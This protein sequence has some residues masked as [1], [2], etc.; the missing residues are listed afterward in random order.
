[1][2]QVTALEMGLANTT[3]TVQGIAADQWDNTTPCA[4]WNVRE[5]VQ[6]TVGVMA[7]FAAAA[8]NQPLPG[9]PMDF[10]MG[11]DPGATCASV[12]R[13]CV[14]NW[15]ERG[16]LE[17]IVTLGE[18]EFPGMVGININ[19]LDAYVHSWD[20]AKATG[21]VAE[22]D[23]DLCAAVHGFAT[24]AVPEAPREGDNFHAV[25]GT[26]GD[27]SYADLMLAYL[28]RQP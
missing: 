10:D 24:Q 18:N 7:N 25:V 19:L 22:L 13:D 15:K 2:E 3:R 14:S 28:G 12:A 26:A 21:Q 6:H 9:D 5:L 16:E 17:S 4:K 1:M 27:A 8:A 11:D 23:E 20:I